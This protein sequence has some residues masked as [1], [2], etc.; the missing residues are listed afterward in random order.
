MGCSSSS[1][2]DHIPET[3]ISTIP[4][5]EDFETKLI[6]EYKT[7]IKLNIE[8]FSVSKQIKG[9][10]ILEY[11]LMRQIDLLSDDDVFD[12]QTTDIFIE[13]T[14]LPLFQKTYIFLKTE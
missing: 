6:N 13:K 1:I 8:I 10:N 2:D 4:N 5:E 14:K 3:T 9:L 11:N 7:I 12:P